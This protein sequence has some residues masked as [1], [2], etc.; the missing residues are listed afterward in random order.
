MLR[1]LK[2]DW[3][4]GGLPVIALALTVA[5]SAVTSVG[6]FN[7][8]V[9]RAMQARAAES[10]GADLVIQSHDPIPP[11][12]SSKAAALG[13]SVSQQIEFTSMVLNDRGIPRLVTVKA[14]DQHYP[15]RG[16]LQSSDGLLAPARTVD[17][18]PEAG[19]LWGHPRL[20][21][22]IGISIKDEVSLGEQSFRV[23]RVL[24]QEPD[25][26]AS[27]FAMA[28]PRVLMRLADVA[29]TGLISATSRAHYRLQ[30][31][32]NGENLD[33]FSGW[34]D[35]AGAQGLERRTTENAQPALRTALDRASSYLGL[36]SLSV[37]IV[38][39][40]GIFL[41]A[42]YYAREQ[43][44]TAAVM[45]CLGA[46]HSRILVTFV[47]RTAV[48]ALVSSFLGA[49]LGYIGQL[50]LAFLAESRLGFTL[51]QASVW[52][53]LTGVAIGLI[54]A[55][56]F[57]L[58]PLLK[59]PNVTVMGLLR[60][61]Q[62]VAPPSAWLSI[63]LVFFTC[64]G[65]VLWQAKD[66]VLAF[67][68]LGLTI[69]LV[70]G[71]TA[72]GWVLLW[73]IGH[74][75]LSSPT[76]RYVLSSL[77]RRAGTGT[78]QVLAFGL[79]MTALL[80]VTVMRTDLLES[81]IN[82]IPPETPN[83]FLINI[84]PGEE[85]A[86]NTFLASE[87]LTSRGMFPMTRGRWVGHNGED[88]NSA[89]YRSGRAQRLA[90]REF[91]LTSA[92]TLPSGNRVVDGVWWVP[93]QY[94]ENL[95]SLEREF[96]AE[97]GIGV[98]DELTFSIAGQQ[99][100]GR[101]AN[102]REVAWDSFEVNF[103]VVSS[104]GLLASQPKTF[105]TSFFMPPDNTRT[106]GRLLERF[107]SVTMFDVDAL[108]RQVRSIIR[109]VSVAV[110]YVFLFTLLAGVTTLI[111]A[112]QG[113]TL[114]RR[115]D[116]A[117]LR[118]LGSSSGRLWLVQFCEYTVLGGIAGLLAAASSVISASVLARE[119]FGFELTS[120]W[121]VWAFGVIGGA[122]GIGTVGALAVVGIVRRAP[123]KSLSW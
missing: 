44:A 43:S 121:P 80:M 117:V 88:I 10:L 18:L 69:A 85:S 26:F 40:A 119:V 9:W 28:A 4:A 115:R 35:T 45:R 94:G 81:W 58:T 84:Q 73:S 48:V 17:T 55:G 106:P 15:L 107:P 60:Q 50:Y 13:L 51:P 100:T 71:L 89:R 123:L 74:I 37:L 82:S 79:G 38:A 76:Q 114:E 32:G 53:L 3:R 47:L 68:V 11:K 102:L 25:D 23:A 67:W 5:V 34:L 30:I 83:R 86:L 96:S 70:I 110:Q 104:P 29:A 14:V 111:A 116:A 87:K 6:V 27:F 54:T 59:L 21:A 109:Q 8:R 103:F 33:E 97:L 120:G 101:V 75:R 20:F 57:A 52:P 12:I 36:A 49:L 24:V 42:V 16:A 39:G 98:G 91:N 61:E 1:G 118:A 95:L 78:V 108:L 22:E 112:V 65:L 99:V 63:G 41:A 31:A 93:A 90:T 72:L 7:D 113:S 122:V 2:H 46:S 19:E 66:P 56:G 105:I 62:A 64:G 92:A 77:V